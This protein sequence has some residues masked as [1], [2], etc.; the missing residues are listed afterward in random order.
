M[1]KFFQI[2]EGQQKSP[3]GFGSSTGFSLLVV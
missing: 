3:S 1:M 2:V